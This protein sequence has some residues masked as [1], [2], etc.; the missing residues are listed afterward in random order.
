[1]IK[2]IIS[3]GQTGADCAALDFAI[4]HEIAHGGW[5]PKGR[6]CETGTIDYRYQLTE[7]ETKNYLERSEKNVLAADATVIFHHLR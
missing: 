5:C 3:G 4:W 6:H 1:M 2:K 7:T